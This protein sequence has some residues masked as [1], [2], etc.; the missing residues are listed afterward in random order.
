MPTQQNPDVPVYLFTGFLEAGKTRFIQETLEDKRFHTDGKTLVVLCEEGE[1]EIDLT[2][3]P[4]NTTVVEIIDDIESFNP[5][6]LEQLRITAEAT[7][8]I[9]EANGMWQLND[10]FSRMPDSWAVYQEMCF[11]DATT[12]LSYNANMRSLVVDKLSSCELVVFNRFNDKLDKIEFHKIVRALSRRTDIAYEYTD[13][14]V[15]YDDIEDPL[16]FD[17]DAPII[18]IADTDYALWYRDIAETPEKYNGKTVSFCGLVA[19]E[20]KFP[21]NTFAVGRHVMTCCVEDI[22]YQCLVAE[23][24]ATNTLKQGQWVKITAKIALSRH[25]LY[26]GKG[27]VLKVTDLVLTTAPDPDVATYY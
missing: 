12:F 5:I 18:E 27:P 24:S 9:L 6:H 16:P 11:V 22:T 7:R 17:I 20:P 21:P 14:H 15:E 3:I 8:V 2:R 26:R 1:E 25:K 19:I 23:W 10:I 13:G 4:K